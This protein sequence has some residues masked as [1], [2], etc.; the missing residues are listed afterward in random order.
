MKHSYHLSR[1][2]WAENKHPIVPLVSIKHNWTKKNN[3]QI[4]FP[5]SHGIFILQRKYLT[6]IWVTLIQEQF[7][8]YSKNVL[9]NMMIMQMNL[10]SRTRIMIHECNILTK[11][12]K[13]YRNG[14]TKKDSIQDHSLLGYSNLIPRGRSGKGPFVLL[15]SFS[16]N[17]FPSLNGLSCALAIRTR[18]GLVFSEDLFPHDLL[19]ES[20]LFFLVGVWD[21]GCHTFLDCFK[22]L[23][24]NQNKFLGLLMKYLPWYIPV[25]AT[26]VIG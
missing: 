5:L 12:L 8:L 10:T 1:L 18:M 7:K 3:L 2:H 9:Y 13:I 16:K 25:N 23:Y 19:P 20:D 4:R 21:E 22:L 14:G 15:A 6:T 26:F 11:L 24:L 17:R